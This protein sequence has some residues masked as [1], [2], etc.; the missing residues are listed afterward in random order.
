MLLVGVA[1]LAI[2]SLAVLRPLVSK[3]PAFVFVAVPPVSLLVSAIILGTAWLRSRRP[4]HR[5]M[6][7]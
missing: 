2:Y 3:P 7:A 6:A 1:S 4:P 5:S